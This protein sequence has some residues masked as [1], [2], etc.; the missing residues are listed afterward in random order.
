MIVN[1][2]CTDQN[3]VV[4]FTADGRPELT[5]EQGQV[6]MAASG[7]RW[8]LLSETTGRAANGAGIG[9]MMG[10]DLD[11]RR[12]VTIGSSLVEDA[13][14][15]AGDLVMWNTEGPSD[16]NTIYDVVYTAARLR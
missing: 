8:V 5:V 7:T 16:S 14:A 1:Y 9:R 2:F 15:V 6:R 4:V 3:H 11:N 13:A 10:L 12:L